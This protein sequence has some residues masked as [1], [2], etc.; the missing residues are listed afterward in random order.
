M[1]RDVRLNPAF[2]LKRQHLFNC[3]APLSRDHDSGQRYGYQLLS[4]V[5][6]VNLRSFAS[7]V[8]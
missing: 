4:V 3:Q 2:Q 8:N 1:C 7:A 5:L 6:S